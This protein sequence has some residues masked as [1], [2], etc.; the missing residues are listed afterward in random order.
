MEQKKILTLVHNKRRPNCREQLHY[1]DSDSKHE[2][3]HQQ[4][5]N[6]NNSKDIS[7]EEKIE[8][9]LRNSLRT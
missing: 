8:Y 6:N 3:M 4:L 9:C 2:D 7:F 5:C 1:W